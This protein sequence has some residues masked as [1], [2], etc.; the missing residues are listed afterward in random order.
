MARPLDIVIV[1]PPALRP[2]FEGR[3]EVSLGMPAGSGVVDVIATLLAL[4]PRLQGQLASDREARRHV[5]LALEEAAAREL[6]RGGTGLES[7]GR[8]YLFEQGGA[9]ERDDPADIEG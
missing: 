2:L 5:V 6:A 8:L 4:Y 1:I 9:A 7:G 3:R